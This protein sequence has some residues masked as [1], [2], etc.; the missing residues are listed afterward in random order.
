MIMVIRDAIEGLNSL[1]KK[2][3]NKLD[4]KK[5]RTDTSPNLYKNFINYIFYFKLLLKISKLT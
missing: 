1:S 4:K 3:N 2:K 5:L